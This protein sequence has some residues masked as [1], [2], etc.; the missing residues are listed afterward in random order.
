V[1]APAE[2]IYRRGALALAFQET[3]TTTVR[4]RTQRQSTT[5]AEAFRA[6]VKQLLKGAHEEARSAGY[7]GEDVKLAVYAVVVF[8]DE[9]VLNSSNPAFAQWPRRPLQEELFGGHMGGETFFQN[10]HGLLGRDD[11]DDL[12]DLVEVHQLCLLLGFKGRYGTSGQDELRGWVRACADRIARIRGSSAGLSPAWAPPEQEVIPLPK[13]R[14]LLP[15][16]LVAG[17]ALLAACVLSLVYWLAQHS[18]VAPTA[19]P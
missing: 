18:W 17:A 7:A 11:S 12:A 9:G 16:S 2:R 3:L 14:L 19:T 15:L 8:L 13:D 4:L 5:D 6:H 10:L 1:A